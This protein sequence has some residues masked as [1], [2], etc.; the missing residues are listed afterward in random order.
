[1]ES[2]PLSEEELQRLQN[3]KRNIIPALENQLYPLRRECDKLIEKQKDYEKTVKMQRE[4]KE[5][6]KKK[7]IYLM[8]EEWV[9]QNKP[10]VYARSQ[11]RLRKDEIRA[12]KIDESCC[13]FRGGYGC[14]PEHQIAS[15]YLRN[16]K[17]QAM[18]RIMRAYIEGL[19][20]FF[21]PFLD[22]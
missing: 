9:K 19:S 6:E 20:Y 11:K 21:C 13:C 18:T 16:A 22:L 3:L 1:M 17:L 14:G 4:D 5:F 7:E 10:N 12:K 15:D 8:M 2:E